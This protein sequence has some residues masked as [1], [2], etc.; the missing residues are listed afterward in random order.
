M[1]NHIGLDVLTNT[2]PFR[3]QFDGQLDIAAWAAY[4]NVT[5]DLSDQFSLKG[6]ARYSL[7][8][9]N[10]ANNT[11]LGSPAL[12]RVVFD[13]LQ[14]DNSKSWNDFSPSLG[15]EFRPDDNWMLYAN[16]SL[17]FKSGTA[18]IGST[19]RMSLSQPL[20]FVEP[21]E[22]EAFEAGLKYESRG[23]NVNLAAF[24]YQLENG[25]FSLT[26]PIPVPPFFTSTLTN[27]AESEG[28][29]AELELLWRA[30][31]EFTINASVAY[32][33]SRFTNFF[34]KDPLDPALFGPGGAA[35]PDQDLS[36]NATRMSPDW[37]LNLFPTYDIDLSNGGTIRLASNFAYR[38]KQYHTEFNDE[39][40]SQGDYI[41]LDAN[42]LYRAP[43]GHLSVNLWAKNITDE[44]VYAGSFSI[45]TSR[46]IGGTLMPPR[47][48]GVT[49][50]Y[51]F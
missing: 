14:W 4:A 27:A 26:R 3:V 48:Y 13:P 17:G 35:V 28:Y 25:Q 29:G 43:D 45:S 1:E 23:L 36:G 18:E 5:Y 19:R 16:W 7:E 30:T 49:V 33:H 9:R 39:R 10:L 47:T 32:L 6:G 51:D 8:E 21:E 37:S 11:G 46:A 42:I 50:G 24:Y 20:P 38:S 34:S 40:L 22:V 12:N 44:L 15:V 41:M 31:P 2:D